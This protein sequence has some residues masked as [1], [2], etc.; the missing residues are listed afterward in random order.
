MLPNM[1]PRRASHGR[2][3]L[4]IKMIVHPI[5]KNEKQM[6]RNKPRGSFAKK[7]GRKASKRGIVIKANGSS[8]GP[9][10]AGRC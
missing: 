10:E 6:N 4:P 9:R 8:K 3:K 7:L 1:L 2:I 5:N